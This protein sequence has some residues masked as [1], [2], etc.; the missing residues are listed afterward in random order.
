[1]L[2]PA[3]A[4]IGV[5]ILVADAADRLAV[6]PGL[7]DANRRSARRRFVGLDNFRDIFGSTSIGRDFKGALAQYRALYRDVGRADPAALGG[8][9]PDGLS[10]LGCR[11]HAAPDRA[12]LH[13]HGADDRGG[14]GMVEALF[15][16]RRA[17]QPDARLRSASGRRH[18]C[19][20]RAPRWSRSCFLNVWQQVGYFTVLAVA[21]LTQIPGSLYE[22]ARARRRQCAG[23]NSAPSRCR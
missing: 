5:F 3:V 6:V 1:M 12:V 15:A 8:A 22:A 14:A 18:G 13:L 7:V 11:R 9:R 17:A 19:R 16:D 2:A 10:A 4:L 21:G 20:R 23:S